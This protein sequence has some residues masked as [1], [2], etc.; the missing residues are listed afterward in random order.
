MTSCF[1]K[2]E[3]AKFDTL[4]DKLMKHAD[5]LVNPKKPTKKRKS[6]RDQE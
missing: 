5:K 3:M 2:E 4:L 6:Y 1:T